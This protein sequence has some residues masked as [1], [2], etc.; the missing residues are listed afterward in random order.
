MG[1]L[2]QIP[3]LCLINFIFSGPRLQ[4]MIPFT[5]GVGTYMCIK[6]SI[7]PLSPSILPFSWSPT[8]STGGTLAPSA[9]APRAVLESGF[10]HGFHHAQLGCNRFLPLSG[11]RGAALCWGVVATA[12][13]PA[14]LSLSYLGPPALKRP[15][16][17][18]EGWHV[19]CTA[20]Y[21]LETGDRFPQPLPESSCPARAFRCLPDFPGLFLSAG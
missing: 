6:V 16:R 15:C 14:L 21:G 19:S 7:L 17:G 11:Q 13:T 18:A 2:Y 8:L 9:P 4:F 20:C 5:V 10:H 1:L 12:L 3:T